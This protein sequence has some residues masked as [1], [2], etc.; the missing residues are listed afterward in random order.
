MVLPFVSICDSSNSLSLPIWCIPVLLTINSHRGNKSKFGNKGNSSSG[1]LTISQKIF[2]CTRKTPEFRTP[3]FRIKAAPWA[4]W[5]NQ[6]QSTTLVF[7]RTVMKTTKSKQVYFCQNVT[8]IKNKKEATPIALM[9]QKLWWMKI[10]AGRHWLEGTMT[11]LSHLHG[12]WKTKQ[13][14]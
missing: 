12:A 2:C 5:W 9:S 14:F 4:F 1:F 11:H 8:Y 7:N 3:Q 6:N 10:P 13:N